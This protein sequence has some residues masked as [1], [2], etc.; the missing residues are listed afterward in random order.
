MSLIKRRERYIA[1]LPATPCTA[2][3]RDAIVQIA[4]KEGVPLAELQR[5]ALQFFLTESVSKYSDM[6]NNTVGK[7]KEVMS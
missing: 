4:E 7:Q 3:M 1:R 5:Y 6:D 2:E